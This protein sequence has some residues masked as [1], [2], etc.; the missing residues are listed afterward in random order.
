MTKFFSSSRSFTDIQEDE[1]LIPPQIVIDDP[2]PDDGKPQITDQDFKPKV[3]I[4][5]RMKPQVMDE[6]FDPKNFI[7]NIMIHRVNDKQF[8]PQIVVDEMKPK[9]MDEDFKPPI[10]VDDMMK[11]P[12]IFIDA[13]V[14]GKPAKD[15][16]DVR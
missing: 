15:N 2:K 5:N 16:S 7:G 4:D 3:N 8:N 13:F 1:P 11:P 10:M 14:D 9:V 6:D 12:E